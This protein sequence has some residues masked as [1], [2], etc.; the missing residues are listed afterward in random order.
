MLSN[1]RDKK[2]DCQSKMVIKICTLAEQGYT[3]EVELWW[4]HNHSIDR[5]HLTTSSPILPASKD[6]FF[7]YF[8]QGM[9]ASELFHY[10]ETLFIKDTVTVLLLADRKYCPSMHDVNNLYEKWRKTTKGPCNGSEMFDHLEEYVTNYNKENE[11]DGGKIFLQ[12]YNNASECEKPL[13]ISICTPMMYRVHKLQQ[14]GEMAFMDASGSH[15]RHNNPVYFMCTHHP[16]GALP[17]AVWVT[18]SQS[19]TTLKCC[20][21][22][23]ISVLPK[24]V[25]GGKGPGVGPSVFLTDDD[26]AQRNALRAYWCSSVLLLCIF[27]FL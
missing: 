17:L 8:E 7:A 3:C 2:T 12:R 18:S 16:S 6:K 11:N 5:H 13:I 19:E 10:H 20:L 23:L 26:T 1:I 4:N 9:S 24:H 15:D 14:A 22:N 21:N 25:F 27:H